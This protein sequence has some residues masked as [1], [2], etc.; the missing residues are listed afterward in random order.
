VRLVERN[1]PVPIIG[2]SLRATSCT[3][4]L[5]SGEVTCRSTYAPPNLELTPTLLWLH[6]SPCTD[7]GL[8]FFLGSFASILLSTRVLRVVIV[9]SRLLDLL[10]PTLPH[11][12]RNVDHFPAC[13]LL[14]SGT[15]KPYGQVACPTLFK[16]R[17]RLRGGRMGL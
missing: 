6:S 10:S 7:P 12:P 17:M 14:T 15:L 4:T 11:S 1:V 2:G 8:S 5:P 13:L 16:S 3:A 9:T